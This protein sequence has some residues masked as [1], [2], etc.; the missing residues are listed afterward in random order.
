[1]Q[2]FQIEFEQLKET[3]EMECKAAQGRD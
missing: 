1:M 2:D 3:H